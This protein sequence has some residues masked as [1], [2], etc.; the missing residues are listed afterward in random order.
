MTEFPARVSCFSS[1]SSFSSDL[2]VFLRLPSPHHFHLHLIF[3]F[4][5]RK[6]KK[7]RKK[8]TSVSFFRIV[9]LFSFLTSRSHR[10]AAAALAGV[11]AARD[12]GTDAHRC[13][14]GGF[15]FQKKG[16]Q[17]RIVSFPTV[18]IVSRR[19]CCASIIIRRRAN[20]RADGK[21]TTRVTIPNCLSAVIQSPTEKWGFRTHPAELRLFRQNPPRGHATPDQQSPPVSLLFFQLSIVGARNSNDISNGTSERCGD[22]YPLSVCLKIIFFFFFSSSEKDI[23]TAASADEEVACCSV[24]AEATWRIE[25]LN[26][27]LGEKPRRK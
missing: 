18:V 1:F 26:F 6:E 3:S 2:G 15:D 5:K 16:Y 19:S 12:T 17:G 25:F 21:N 23:P 24:W 4:E 20:N 10:S 14:G 13:G 9:F 22:R 7:K 27:F 11:L 8:S